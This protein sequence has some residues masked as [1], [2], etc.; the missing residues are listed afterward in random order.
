MT[1]LKCEWSWIEGMEIIH[2]GNSYPYQIMQT[3]IV[4]RKTVS[5]E[6]T[7][8]VRTEYSVCPDCIKK[9]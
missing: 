3:V 4:D 7:F 9:V 1:S 8:Q 2:C 6:G 5:Q